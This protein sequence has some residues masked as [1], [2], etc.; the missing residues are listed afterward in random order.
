MDYKLDLVGTEQRSIVLGIYRSQPARA[1]SMERRRSHSGV[2]AESALR[3]NYAHAHTVDTRPLF[4]SSGAYRE[5]KGLGTR[6]S[7]YTQMILQ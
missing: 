1:A 2:I 4:S 6:L 5:K 7:Y 3:S